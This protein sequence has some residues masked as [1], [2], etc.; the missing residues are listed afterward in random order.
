M[1]VQGAYTVLGAVLALIGIACVV[2][3][4]SVSGRGGSPS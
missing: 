2:W 4:W 3:A 1:V